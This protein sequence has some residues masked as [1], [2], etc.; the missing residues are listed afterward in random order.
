[1]PKTEGQ[2]YSIISLQALLD[3]GKNINIQDENLSTPLMIA[4]AHGHITI[5][6]ELL[7]RGNVLQYLG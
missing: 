6:K 3:G 5:V 4:A 1:M 7:Y 2:K